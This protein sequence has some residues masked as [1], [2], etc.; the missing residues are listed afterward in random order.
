QG[1]AEAILIDQYEMVTEGAATTVWMVDQN[2]ALR[3]RPL[4]HAILAGCTREA[5]AA[6]LRDAGID[7]EERAFSKAELCSASEIFLTGATSFVKPVV[8]LDNF[9]VGE[10]ITGPVTRHLFELFARHVGTQPG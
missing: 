3:T 4:D 9:P 2:G 1:A 8:Q 10:G 7:F 6:L 5:L